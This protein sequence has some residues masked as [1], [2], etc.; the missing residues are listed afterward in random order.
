MTMSLSKEQANAY[1]SIIELFN[2]PEPQSAILMGAAGTGKT[3]LTDKLSE[4]LTPK[5]SALTHKAAA[6]MNKQ[7]GR[8]VITLAKL[9]KQKKY[10]DLDTGESKFKSPESI[11]L[12]SDVKTVLIDESSMMN[13]EN[14]E[15][16]QN[17]IAP[18]YNVLRIGDRFQLPPVGEHY[19]MALTDDC[20]KFE[21]L[22]PQRFDANS[23]IDRTAVSIRTAL[24]QGL[25]NVPG[26]AEIL[27]SCDDVLWL[28]A[29]DAVPMMIEDFKNGTDVDD[30]RMIS[31]TNARVESFNYHLKHAVTGDSNYLQVGDLVMA[32]ETIAV[33]RKSADPFTKETVTETIVQNNQTYKIEE[34]SYETVENV[35]CYRLS[36]DNGKDVNVAI[37]RREVDSLVADLRNRALSFPSGSKDRGRTFARMFELKESFAD[38]RLNYAQTV[39]KSQGSTYQT[40]YFD[41]ENL[42]SKSNLGKQLLYTGVTRAAKRLVLFK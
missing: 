29:E 28:K 26:M 40:C 39:H 24:E 21:L 18:R 9:L 11:K 36:L 13:K 7:T 20:P 35:K 27:K 32:N 22:E 19:S 42:D 33:T 41:L 1:D 4:V 23:G 15:Q 2:S 34:L 10:N 12:D 14:Y 16:V 3:F 31:F 6:V 5:L 38:M 30:V 8:E 25:P 17:L 37:D